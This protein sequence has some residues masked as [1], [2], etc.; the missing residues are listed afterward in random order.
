MSHRMAVLINSMAGFFEDRKNDRFTSINGLMPPRQSRRMASIF[1]QVNAIQQADKAAPSDD[2]EAKALAFL[3]EVI[4]EGNIRHAPCCHW[5]CG[6]PCSCDWPAKCR[7]LKRW[8]SLRKRT[9]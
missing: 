4:K 3:S 5:W 9:K 2:T 6:E 7:N 8:L 1:R